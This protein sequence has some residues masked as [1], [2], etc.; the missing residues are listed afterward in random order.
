MSQLAEVVLTIDELEALRLADLEGMYQ[1]D[2][3]AKMK[4]SR[5]TFGRIITAARKKVAEVLVQGK[6]LRIEGGEFHAPVVRIFQC[7]D[8]GWN[9][10]VPHG[11]GRPGVCPQ[12]HGRNFHR[13]DNG[14]GQIVGRRGR[15]RAE[16]EQA[17]VSPEESGRKPP[18]EG[19]N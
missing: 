6:A 17:G 7:K 14:R 11:T 15:C 9:W 12:C 18:E 5:Q 13:A 8:C 2:A 19:G 4:V 16:E 1:E 10:Q 3:A